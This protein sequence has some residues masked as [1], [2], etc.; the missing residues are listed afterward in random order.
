MPGLAS[1]YK[2]HLTGKVRWQ[3]AYILRKIGKDHPVAI[4]ALVELIRNSDDEG[5]R[6]LAADSLGQIDKDNPVAIS[7]LVELIRNSGNEDTRR[8][9]A[10][11]LGKIGKDNP[12]VISALVEL[13]RNSGNEDT[14][15]RLAA[16]S[17]GEIDKDIAFSPIMR[18]NGNN[19]QTNYEYRL[20]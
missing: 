1:C 6:R 9:A 14:R 7:A 12:V 18:Y 13:I 15:R 3:A 8:H 5:T 4:S 20:E 2:S 17:L 16:Y 10:F 11:S 19:E